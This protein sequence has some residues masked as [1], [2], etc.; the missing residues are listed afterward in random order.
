MKR[1]EKEIERE[2]NEREEKAMEHEFRMK[3]RKGS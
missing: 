3:Q 1:L 2:K